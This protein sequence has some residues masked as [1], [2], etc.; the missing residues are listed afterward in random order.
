[1]TDPKKTRP[2]VAADI[3]AMAA[4]ADSTLFPGDML[5]EMIA[6]YLEGD[7]DG[8]W[9]VIEGDGCVVGFAFATV[10]PMTDQSWNLKAIAVK[11]EQHRAGFGNGLLSAVEQDL[12]AYG[13]RVLVID[14][15]SGDDQ[16]AARRFYV[17]HGY[18]QTGVIPE[19]WEPGQDKVTFYKAF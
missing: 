15:S 13:A 16:A 5:P 6:P 11:P 8:R 1:M 19:F 2:V 3:L 7:T 18:S 9:W 14:T 12:R 10:E 4:I 17:A